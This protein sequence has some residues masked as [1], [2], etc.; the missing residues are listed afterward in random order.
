MTLN[1]HTQQQMQEYLPNRKLEDNQ[2]ETDNR[3]QFII[4]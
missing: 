1:L 4:F 2:D 3:A